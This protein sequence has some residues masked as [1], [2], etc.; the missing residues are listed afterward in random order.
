MLTPERI[1]ELLAEGRRLREAFEKRIAP[2]K[3]PDPSTQHL[4]CK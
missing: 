3:I 2:M 1:A 4:P